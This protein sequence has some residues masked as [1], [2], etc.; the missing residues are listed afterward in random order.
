MFVNNINPILFNIGPFSVRYYGLLYAAAFLISYLF[1]RYYRKKGLL[2][3][4][5]NQLDSYFLW[6]I[7]GIIVGAR[8][9]EVFVYSVDYY[10]H[11]L[12]EIIQIWNG[13]LSFHGGLIGAVIVTALF[14]K[15]YKIQFYDIADL[16]AIPATIGLFLGRIANYTNSELYGTIADP[17]KTSWCVVF[18]KVDNYCRHPTQ[19]YEALKNVVMFT[20]LFVYQ[21]RKTKSYKKG[22][23]FWLFVLMYGVLRFFITFLRDEPTYFGL[24][25][26]QWFCAAM[27]ITAA[28][29]LWTGH[30]RS[31]NPKVYK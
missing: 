16:L 8:L 30:E 17:A 23:I 29:F 2:K 26:G 5:E 31:T 18:Q 4:T 13:G 12:N 3:I 10:I 21:K 6:L 27:A 28:V 20:V 9:F 19:L 24:N 1:M 11:H 7:V 15:K 25:V 14:C 22:T